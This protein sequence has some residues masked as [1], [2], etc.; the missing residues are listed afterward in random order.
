MFHEAARMSTDSFM[1]I[2][3]PIPGAGSKSHVIVLDSALG[4]L[5]E[6]FED[7]VDQMETGINECK[8]HGE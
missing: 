8:L 5:Y 3:S 1:Q 4:R 2:D 6:L 7:L